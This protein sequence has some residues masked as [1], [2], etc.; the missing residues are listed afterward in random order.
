M[1]TFNSPKHA[2]ARE[3]LTI[4]NAVKTLTA[5][6]YDPSSDHKRATGARIAVLSGSGTFTFTEDGTTPTADA[7]TVSG[8]GT[9]AEAGDIIYLESFA[10]VSNFKAIRVATDAIVEVVYYR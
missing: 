1:P 4:T 2:F 10:A 8:V 6:T 5:A 9:P 3:R 7:T